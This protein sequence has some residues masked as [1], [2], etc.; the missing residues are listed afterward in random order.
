MKTLLSFLL[1]FISIQSYSQCCDTYDAYA[2]DESNDQLVGVDISTGNYTVIAPMTGAT[3][4]VNGGELV[5][6]N[7]YLSLNDGSIGMI[8]LTTGVVTTVIPACAASITSIDLDPTTGILYGLDVP[9]CGSGSQI[10]SIDLG[11]GTCSTIGA[12]NGQFPC[13][14]SLVID[15][16]GQG[17]IIDVVNDNITP[18][19]L[20]T[21]LSSGPSLS[22]GFDLNFGQEYEF[23]C[24]LGGSTIYG[25]AFNGSTFTAQFVTIDPSTGT[26]TI[27]QD[28]GSNQI[29]SF[30][31]CEFSPPP[32]PT[33]SQWGLF[34]LMVLISIIGLISIRQFRVNRNVHLN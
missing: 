26:T 32:I 2:I 23:D 34:I 16:T 17:Y 29:T 7:Y 21:G 9:S 5:D 6:C 31:F 22:L 12:I 8:D 20:A 25:Y 14:I 13:G 30:S 10:I 27:I 19:D 28:T 18:I 3:A 33:M 4:F 24:P 11:A 1:L 15:A